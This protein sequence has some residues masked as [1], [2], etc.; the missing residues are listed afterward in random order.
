VD[1]VHA[2]SEGLYRSNQNSSPVMTSSK[3]IGSC[4]SSMARSRLE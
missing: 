1:V 2:A 4:C 3:S